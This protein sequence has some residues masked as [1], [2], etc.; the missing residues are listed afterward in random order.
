MSYLRHI[1]S[2]ANFY[3]TIEPIYWMVYPFSPEN[4]SP[5]IKLSNLT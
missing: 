2:K 5:N 1:E 3:M 4:T